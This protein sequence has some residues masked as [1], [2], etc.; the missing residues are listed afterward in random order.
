MGAASSG[1]LRLRPVSFR[2]KQPYEDGSK[3]LDYGLIAEEVEEVY[4]DL[5]IKNKDGR[6][7]TVQYQKL[8]PMLAPGIQE[9]ATT[10]RR[11]AAGV[12]EFISEP[13]SFFGHQCGN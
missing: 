4:P 10:A 5:V 6:V 3:P 9:S 12:N 11:A 7:E 1:L 2:Y 8:T 13:S